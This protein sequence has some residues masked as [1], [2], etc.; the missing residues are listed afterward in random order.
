MISAAQTREIAKLLAHGVPRREIARR[1]RVSRDTVARIAALPTAIHIARESAARD[2]DDDDGDLC[3]VP[4]AS[5]CQRC[6]GCGGLV[7]A[8]CR[9]CAARRASGAPLPPPT[10]KELAADY[11]EPRPEEIAAFYRQRAT[12]RMRAHQEALAAARQRAEDDA[13]SDTLDADF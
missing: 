10:P 9:L 7:L 13:D 2:R 1:A 11:F 4:H 8:P 5:Q 3:A 6:P 12:D